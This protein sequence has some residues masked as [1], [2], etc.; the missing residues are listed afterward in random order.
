MEAK[1]VVGTYID[2]V[3]D[4]YARV[5]TSVRTI[6]GDTDLFSVEVGLHQG[7]ALSLF[8]FASVI[9]ELTKKVQGEVPWC[10]LFADD[11]ML[12]DE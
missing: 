11:I 3:K 10:M 9:N 4:M 5:M 8:L 1:G 6:G 12:I 7:S 2:L